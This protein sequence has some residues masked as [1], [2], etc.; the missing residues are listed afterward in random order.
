M[1][2][3]IM[4]VDLFELANNHVWET[5]FGFP[6]WY[7][8]FAPDFMQI[9]KNESGFTEKGWIDFGLQTYYAF[10]N[11]GFELMPTA[12]TAAGVHPVPAGFGRVYVHQPDGLSVEG[13]LKGLKAGRS[14]VTTGPM[15]LAECE[16]RPSGDRLRPAAASKQVRVTGIAES[17]TPLDRVEV[18]VNGRLVK[19]IA[20]ANA[21]RKAG[22]FAS[23]FD[24]PIDVDGSSWLI[25]RAY[26]V[27]S[28]GRFRFAH[29]APWFID[30]PGKPLAPRAEE[31]DYFIGRVEAEIDRNRGVLKPEEIAEY[32]RALEIYREIRKR[33]GEPAKT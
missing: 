20:A 11:C 5:E 6:Q 9:E 13:W 21:P 33:A 32:E 24:E 2:V 15:L 7:A 27:R 8:D 12:G 3:P 25:V 10:L 23:K 1:I 4:E 14:F 31:V 22:G 29:T 28:G 19:T 18:V 17:S 16:G 30:V 26:E